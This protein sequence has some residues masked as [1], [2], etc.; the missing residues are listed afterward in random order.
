[1]VSAATDIGLLIARLVSFR[2]QSLRQLKLI[3]ATSRPVGAGLLAADVLKGIRPTML[4]TLSFIDCDLTLADLSSALCVPLA[5][6]YLTIASDRV[7]TPTIGILLNCGDYFAA[8]QKSRAGNSLKGL[9]FD[10]TQEGFIVAPA[11]GLRG[12]KSILYL[13]VAKDHIEANEQ[14]LLDLSLVPPPDIRCSLEQLLPVNLE[15][16]KISPDAADLPTLS[17]ILHRRED[18]VPRLRKIILS[19]NYRSKE[20]RDELVAALRKGYNPIPD[21]IPLYTHEVYNTYRCHEKKH[22]LRQLRALC[23]EKGVVLMLI[24]EDSMRRE[25]L[26]EGAGPAVWEIEDQVKC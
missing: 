17:L 13:E 14:M 6:Q 16:L 21:S 23:E 18:I 9:R 12:L 3:R 8:I 26:G 11:P 24:Y 15:V 19:L 10:M 1:M 25:I 2:H 22:E 7:N 5:L 4:E 20:M